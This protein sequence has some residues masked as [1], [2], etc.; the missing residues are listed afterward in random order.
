M[1]TAAN[2]DKGIYYLPL[3]KVNT[4]T[5]SFWKQSYLSMKFVY[6]YKLNLTTFSRHRKDAIVIL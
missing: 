4:G 2:R 1:M 5:L 3:L 6:F